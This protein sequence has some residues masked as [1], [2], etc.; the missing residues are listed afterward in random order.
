MSNVWLPTLFLL[1]FVYVGVQ[2]SK[3]RQESGHK[4]VAWSPFVFCFGKCKQGSCSECLAW[5]PSFFPPRRYEQRGRCKCVAWSPSISGLTYMVHGWGE[6][7]PFGLYPH[8]ATRVGL[9]HSCR[10]LLHICW[11]IGTPSEFLLASFA[12]L[13]AVM[14]LLCLPCS[15]VREFALGGNP[16]KVWAM[17]VH[18]GLS[19]G[20]RHCS[21]EGLFCLFLREIS[22]LIHSWH[23]WT[24]R[25]CIRRCRFR[26]SI[27]KTYWENKSYYSYYRCSFSG[28]PWSNCRY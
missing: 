21:V 4:Y 11:Q 15:G 26:P 20:F 7:L 16:G 9:Y 10:A 28:R 18:L 25:G 8:P 1:L 27:S 24:Y 17:G 19:Q 13:M 5:S 6:H 14:L 22:L 2:I 23:S 3:C 12:G